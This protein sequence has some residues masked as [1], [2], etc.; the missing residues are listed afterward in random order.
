MQVNL[1][2]QFCKREEGETLLKNFKT[3]KSNFSNLQCKRE[4]LILDKFASLKRAKNEKFVNKIEFW[5]RLIM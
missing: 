5:V 4:K 1:V 2:S 3:G